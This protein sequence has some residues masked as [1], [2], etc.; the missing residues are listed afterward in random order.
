M[1]NTKFPG[2][3][4]PAATFMLMLVLFPAFGQEDQIPFDVS[5]SVDWSRGEL[6][7]QA[8]FSL[9]QAGLKLPAGRYRGEE[10]L[11]DAYPGLLRPR[12]LA[13][14]VDSNST[15]GDLLDRGELSLEDLD[16]LS[17]AALKTP[18]SLSA[19]LARMVGRYT[20]PMERISALLSR[21]Q[22][23]ETEAAGPLIPVRAADYTGIIII[24][25]EALP[26]HGRNTRALAEPCLFPKI[27]DT[28]MELIYERNMISPASREGSL[29]A[30]YIVS[31]N[32]FRPTPSGLDGDI[33][34]FLGPNPLRIIAR[35]IFGISPT[36]PVI[37]R[38]D[39]LKILSTENNRRLLREGRV[40]L[41]L[42]AA[43]L[44]STVK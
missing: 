33:A 20:V 27:W 19:D 14:R 1:M 25:D 12:L 17:R 43:Q 31:G 28:D 30:R 10:I 6:N 38:A 26:V 11:D 16:T 44:T 13:L 18:P 4:I 34:A 37:D 22:G 24:A 36:D 9:A 35:E 2:H 41:V 15:V 7:A 32:I 42:N 40:A 21:G 23:R 5:A 3:A 8:S 29:M 39:A